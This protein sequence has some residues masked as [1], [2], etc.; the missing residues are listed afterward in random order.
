MD[1]LNHIIMYLATEYTQHV[2]W[3]PYLPDIQ[4]T[5]PFWISDIENSEHRHDVFTGKTKPCKLKNN[6]IIDWLNISG[7]I[8]KGCKA[9]IFSKAKKIT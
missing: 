7:V 1:L 2:L 4:I 6:V 9:D 3:D 8:S 5:G